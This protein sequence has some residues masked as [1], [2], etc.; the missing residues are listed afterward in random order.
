MVPTELQPLVPTT[1]DRP[2]CGCRA[3]T[4]GRWSP[5]ARE[6]VKESGGH[7]MAV[8][9]LPTKSG[10]LDEFGPRVLGSVY[11][12]RFFFFFDGNTVCL[13]SG[14]TKIKSSRKVCSTQTS[15]GYCPGINPSTQKRAR[16]KCPRMW[17]KR[18]RRFQLLRSGGQGT[19]EDATTHTAAVSVFHGTVKG[20]AV[21]HVYSPFGEV[22]R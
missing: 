5:W 20:V 18:R 7:P 9:F 2:H 13:N 22:G 3:L 4:T 8:E 10:S 12:I 1:L 16:L 19:G 6:R 11:G 17:K 21:F 14:Y 15:L